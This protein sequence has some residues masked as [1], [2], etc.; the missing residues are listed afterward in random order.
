MHL[1]IILLN[2]KTIIVAE[3]IIKIPYVI[4]RSYKHISP[5]GKY[6]VKQRKIRGKLKFEFLFIYI[7]HINS[8]FFFFLCILSYKYNSE[9][10]KI[11]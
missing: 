3:D 6:Y 11:L 2:S 4:F 5:V 1:L 7:F 9:L 10:S 8:F